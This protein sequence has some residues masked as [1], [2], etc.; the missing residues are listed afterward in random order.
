MNT[1]VEKLIARLF[2]IPVSAVFTFGLLNQFGNS[3]NSVIYRLTEDYEPIYLRFDTR[4]T[5]LFWTFII[6]LLTYVL[7]EFLA[8]RHADFRFSRVL[9]NFRYAPIAILIFSA[10]IV[11]VFDF[12]MIEHS[13]YQIRTYVFSDSE[14]VV[15][16]DFLLFNNDRG[17]CG[18]GV[19][20]HENYLYF[21]TAAEGINRENPYVRARSLLIAAKVRNWINGGDRRFDAFLEE[22]LNDPNPV[23]RRTAECISNLDN[24]QCSEIFPED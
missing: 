24:R 15:R 1:R 20:A 18:N 5:V 22:S 6:W 2:F 7:L 9:T 8:C 14:K 11:T 10:L 19:A 13:K 17:W 23:I 4:A 3:L 12:A 16:P 21:D